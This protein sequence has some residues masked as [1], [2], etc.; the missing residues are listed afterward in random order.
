MQLGND[1]F[2]ENY[3]KNLLN[4]EIDTTHV[5]MVDE[6]SGVAQITVNENGTCWSFDIGI[7]NKL[8]AFTQMNHNN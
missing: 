3:L 4:H 8:Y 2:G 5:Q 6:M 7:I 1:L